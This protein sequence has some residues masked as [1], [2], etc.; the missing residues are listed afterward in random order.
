MQSET[1]VIWLLVQ[2]TYRFFIYSRGIVLYASWFLKTTV[3][4]TLFIL[5]SSLTV[6]SVGFWKHWQSDTSS[7][8]C[9]SLTDHWF[10][11]TLGEWDLL[12]LPF[13]LTNGSVYACWFLEALP[14]WDLFNHPSSLT[15]LLVSGNT[16]R[17]SPLSLPFSLTDSN[18][19]ACWFLK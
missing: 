16:G 9:S 14:E 11:E 18:V 3:S 12:N 4:E 1:S 2:L 6:A 7:S 17:V 10:L 15:R 8:F 19:Y 13:T 5:P